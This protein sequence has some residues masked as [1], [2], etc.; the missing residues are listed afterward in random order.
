MSPVVVGLTGPRQ[1]ALFE[2]SS[3]P[4]ERDQVRI[5]TLLSGVS[6]GTE[7]AF[8]RG[9]N[10][11]LEKR[12]DPSLRVFLAGNG[13]SVEYPV[14]TWGYEEVGAGV[15]VGAGVEHIS[16]GSGGFGPW[17]H[18]EEYIAPAAF[19][20]ERTLDPGVPPIIG[21]FSHIG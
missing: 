1:V 18:R 4:L 19:V 20:R 16:P 3:R 11:H 2:E 15:G 17:G 5:R 13:R 7:M 12:W 9:T 10:P 8:Y 21:I 14:M 6:A